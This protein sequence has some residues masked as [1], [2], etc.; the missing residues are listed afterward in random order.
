MDKADDQDEGTAEVHVKEEVIDEAHE[1][2]VGV[3]IEVPCKNTNEESQI[4]TQM[5]EDSQMKEDYDETDMVTEEASMI[6]P[7]LLRDQDTRGVLHH[8]LGPKFAILSLDYPAGT[9]ALLH[10]DRMW[11]TDH[12][13]LGGFGWEVLTLPAEQGVRVNARRVRGFEEFDYQVHLYIVVFFIV[14]FHLR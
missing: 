12:P 6:L 11:V 3:K 9:K 1:P 7:E 5:K 13:M 2:D 4:V 8:E 14:T 10:C